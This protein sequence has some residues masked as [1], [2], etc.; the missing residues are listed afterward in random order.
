MSPGVL[1]IPEDAFRDLASEDEDDKVYATAFSSIATRLDAT[2]GAFI[3][4]DGQETIQAIALG[5]SD[6]V[7]LTE[8]QAAAIVH[9]GE[10]PQPLAML[11][12]FFA[13]ILTLPIQGIAMEHFSLVLGRDDRI[14]DE[15]DSKN[16]EDLVAALSPLIAAR[17]RRA[18]CEQ[19]RIEAERALK[20]AEERVESLFEESHD[21]IYSV[22]NDDTIVSL[23]SAGL[24]LL[25]LRMRAEAIGKSFTSF[26]YTPSD[27]SELLKKIAIQGYVD[28]YEIILKR[29][30][31]DPVFCIESAQYVRGPSGTIAGI[32]GIVKDISERIFQERELWKTNMELTTT[33]NRL[34]AT[35]VLMVQHEKLASIGQLAA[36]VAHEIN[37]PL[38]FLSSNHTTFIQFV[39][40]IRDAWEAITASS[41]SLSESVNGQFDLAYVFSEINTM[42]AETSDGLARIVAIVRNLKSFAR[43]EMETTIGPYDINKGIENTLVVAKNE[44]KY[45]AD[46]DLR[47]GKLREIE[48]SAGE[49]NQVL[50]NL[51]VNSAQAIE[52]QRREERG[53]I[54]IETR[55][56]DGRAICEISDDGPGVPDELRHRIFDP[57]FTTKGPGKGTGLGL[58]ISYD[59]IVK[60]HGGALSVGRSPMGGALF[61]MELPFLHS[62]PLAEGEQ[63]RVTKAISDYSA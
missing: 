8:D 22:D 5:K 12:I 48:A 57:F 15:G 20:K 43:A 2:G 62:G 56:A 51:L 44:I 16:G 36:G 33:N 31:G 47:L 45:V 4:R 18:R 35:E 26:A 46:V 19:A 59:L 14:F 32:Q 52:G 24:S 28:D 27:R 17:Y 6:R 63:G 42:L 53:H 7:Q 50:L 30:G 61:R 13:Y 25:G 29:A 10:A 39:K 34:K 49:I 1:L 41:P 60:K 54:L 38:S 21:M 58:S 23:N 3:Y 9:G 40:T 11:D 37:N 55:D